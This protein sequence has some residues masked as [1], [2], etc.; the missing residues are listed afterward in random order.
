MAV[1]S[2]KKF[3][4]KRSELQS[5]NPILA[6]HGSEVGIVSSKFGNIGDG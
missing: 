5:S 2:S 3:S 1:C 6:Y 4:N